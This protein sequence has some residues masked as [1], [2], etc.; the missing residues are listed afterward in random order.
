MQDVLRSQTSAQEENNSHSG[1]ELIEREDIEGT[2]FK[3][4]TQQGTVFIGLGKYRMTEPLERTAENKE[5]LRQ[6][7]MNKDWRLIM[8]TIAVLTLK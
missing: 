7:V 5:K 4:I 2:P 6:Q 8:D 1:E 3:L